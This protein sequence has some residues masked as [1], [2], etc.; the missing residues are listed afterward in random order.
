M[1][2]FI[3]PKWLHFRDFLGP[4]P[5]RFRK[6]ITVRNSA[7]ADLTETTSKKTWAGGADEP[8]KDESAFGSAAASSLLVRPPPAFA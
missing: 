8:G 3:M 5:G 4:P 6:S 2:V 1:P 7:R